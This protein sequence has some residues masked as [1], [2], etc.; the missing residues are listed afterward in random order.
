VINFNGWNV[1]S[2][3]GN[4][5]GKSCD[6]YLQH[7]PQARFLIETYLCGGLDMS[8]M[9]KD[10]DRI[11]DCPCRSIEIAFGELSPRH[12]VCEDAVDQA[13]HAAGVVQNEVRTVLNDASIEHVHFRIV[14]ELCA[15]APVQRQDKRG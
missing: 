8:G 5:G 6:K 3:L 15:L 12:P 2:R 10:C 1:F 7:R 13:R 9:H 11:A 14:G 4:T